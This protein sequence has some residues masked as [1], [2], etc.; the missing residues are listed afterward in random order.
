MQDKTRD[1]LRQ[2][3]TA[4]ISY[5]LLKRGIRDIYMQG[6]APLNPGGERVV[7]V[8]YTLR[9]IPAREDVSDLANLGSAANLARRAIEEC[10]AGAILTVDARREAHCGTIG[11]ILATRLKVRGAAGMVTD[12]GVRD[13]EAVKAVGL[14]VFSAGPAA[15]AS[16]VLHIPAGLQEPIACGG[17]AVYPGDV[18]VADGDGCVVVPQELADSV[19]EDATGQEGIEAF[20]QKL[21]AA[22]RPVIGTYPPTDAVRREYETWL[23]EGCPEITRIAEN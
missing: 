18:I 16:P 13:A 5:Q 14:P 12:G 22:G 20:V 17:V 19:A 15:P 10:P 7:G 11:D 6:V 4:T 3:T 1:R 8:A 2:I 21:V 9:Y 23:S